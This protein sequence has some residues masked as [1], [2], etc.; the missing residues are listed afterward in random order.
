MRTAAIQIRG[1]STAQNNRGDAFTA[2][3]QTA[4]GF[5]IVRPDELDD[6]RP[7][8]DAYI[9]AATA[10]CIR[11]D[12]R[13]VAIGARRNICDVDADRGYA[14]NAVGVPP[15]L[16]WRHT[17]IPRPD[18]AAPKGQVTGFRPDDLP[19]E[20]DAIRPQAPAGCRAVQAKA[21][22]PGRVDIR[23]RVVRGK[24]KI[25]KAF[26]TSVSSFHN[27]LLGSGRW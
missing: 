23:L 5:G 27:R 7:D 25:D 15:V 18:I 14:S 22:C 20:P 19:I 17:Q 6:R 12:K 16:A 13:A 21:T 1:G 10:D 26:N 3:L 4:S 2:R 9:A 11:A 24:G 8:A